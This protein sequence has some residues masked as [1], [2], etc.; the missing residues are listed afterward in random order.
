ML[1]SVIYV[2]IGVTVDACTYTSFQN[3][4]VFNW[5]CPKCIADVMPFHDCSVL[6]SSSS[7]TSDI[8]SHCGSTKFNITC[9]FE[10][11]SS[12]LS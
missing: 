6:S 4:G 7:D 10:N 1:C 9:W 3:V 11:N 5:S 8:I 2:L 12:K